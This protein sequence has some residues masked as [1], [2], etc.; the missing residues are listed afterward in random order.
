MI[1][2]RGIRSEP[3][4]VMTTSGKKTDIEAWTRGG[5]DEQ[6]TQTNASSA[7]IKG[8]LL[9]AHKCWIPLKNSRSI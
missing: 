3:V 7:S 8:E 5:P 4:G 2:L 9:D 6:L 1:I